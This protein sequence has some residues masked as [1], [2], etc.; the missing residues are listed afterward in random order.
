MER[1][2]RIN[3][4]LD[5]DNTII[6]ALDESERQFLPFFY[7]NKFEFHDMVPTFR[8]FG[9]PYLKEFTDYIFNNCNV[10]VYTA[11]E[12][13]YANFI[14]DRFL[15]RQDTTRSLDF[16]LSRDEINLGAQSFDGRTKPLGNIC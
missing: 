11:A 4:I 7:Q 2:K 16:F 14:I 12:R 10:S 5:L 13:S 1:P 15:T 8:V 3:V 6:N 9:R